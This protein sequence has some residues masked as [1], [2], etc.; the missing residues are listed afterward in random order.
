MSTCFII[1]FI[2]LIFAAIN[3][4]QSVPLNHFI[5]GMFLNQFADWLEENVTHWIFDGAFIDIMWRS[6]ADILNTENLIFC[7]TERKK[8]SDFDVKMQQIRFFFVLNAKRLNFTWNVFLCEASFS[9]YLF[10]AAHHV[11]DTTELFQCP[12]MTRGRHLLT[13]RRIIT[14]PRVNILSLG[15]NRTGV[16]VVINWHFVFL[17]REQKQLW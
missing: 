14:P 2:K 12:S 15:P 4:Q 6:R 9:F 13:N 5:I 8:R 7:F 1:C 10:N 11:I 3:N 17:K 16:C